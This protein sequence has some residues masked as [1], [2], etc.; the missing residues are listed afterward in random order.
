M[1]VKETPSFGA[2]DYD[3]DGN[4][5]IVARQDA[6]GELWLYP[7]KACA[8]TAASRARRSETAGSRVL[9][10]GPPTAR[11]GRPP[12]GTVTLCSATHASVGSSPGALS[13]DPPR[14]WGVPSGDR[15]RMTS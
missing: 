2:P 9:D 15:Q 4:K 12:D 10:G 6:T 3:R 8:A 13:L 5:D 11:L 7:A 1:S 14:R